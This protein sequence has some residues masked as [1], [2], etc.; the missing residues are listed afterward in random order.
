MAKALA[1]HALQ[2]DRA[3]GKAKS[4]VKYRGTHL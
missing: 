1:E 4:V 2:A 3:I